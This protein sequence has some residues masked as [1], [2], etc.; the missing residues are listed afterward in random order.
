MHGGDAAL[1]GKDCPGK[2]GISNHDVCFGVCG[3]AHYD[4]EAHGRDRVCVLMKLPRQ[5]KP[6]S[7]SSLKRHA[8]LRSQGP[9]S[10][11]ATPHGVTTHY[12]ILYLFPLLSPVHGQ[13]VLLCTGSVTNS[14]A[15]IPTHRNA[16]ESR[17]SHDCHPDSMSLRNLVLHVSRYIISRCSQLT[18]RQVRRRESIRRCVGCAL[19]ETM[20]WRERAECTRGCHDGGP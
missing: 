6:D 10:M 3:V 16:A 19:W 13:L 8:R 1:Y 20:A 5:R 4:L 14:S 17:H 12:P 11:A 18:R 7:D 9:G 2:L 15:V